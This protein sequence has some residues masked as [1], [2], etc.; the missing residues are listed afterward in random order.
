MERRQSGLHQKS[1]WGGTRNECRT[2]KE[3]HGKTGGTGKAAPVPDGQG[4]CSLH[5]GQVDHFR[6]TATA[7][8]G[9]GPSDRRAAGGH[10][11]NRRSLEGRRVVTA[12]S[13]GQ[14]RDFLPRLLAQIGVAQGRLL[15]LISLL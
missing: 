12:I 4:R 8:R 10:R 11:G 14:K 1:E 3:P 9:D 6:S 7:R 2:N 5:S 15:G 13:D